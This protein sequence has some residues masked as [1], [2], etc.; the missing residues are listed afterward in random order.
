MSE[1]NWR[2][3]QRKLEGRCTYCVPESLPK[4]KGVCPVYGEELIKTYKDIAEGINE[5]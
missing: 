2:H 5:G 1:T 4:H 3:I